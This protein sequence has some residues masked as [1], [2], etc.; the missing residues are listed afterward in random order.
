MRLSALTIPGSPG[1][2]QARVLIVIVLM[3]LMVPGIH[4]SCRCQC[5]PRARTG[6][7]PGAHAGRST[8]SARTTSARALTQRP[9]R[10]KGGTA[11]LLRRS[12]I[13]VRQS[14]GGT[15]SAELAMARLRILL[16]HSP[17]LEDG[18]ADS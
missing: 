11:H 18:P 16:L 4:W 7:R 17:R 14:P 6:E 15:D 10:A 13:A 3:T 1:R 12:L 2:A 8:G 9:R 5:Q